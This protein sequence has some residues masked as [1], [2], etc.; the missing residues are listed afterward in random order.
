MVVLKTR[1]IMW[2]RLVLLE[3]TN[4]VKIKFLFIKP[5]TRGQLSKYVYIFCKS[6][7]AYKSI[8]KI[9]VYFL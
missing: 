9:I 6:D 8:N 4:F 5:L 2:V 7:Q 1:N 3:M